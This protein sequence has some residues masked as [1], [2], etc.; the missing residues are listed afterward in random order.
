[1]NCGNGHHIE[2]PQAPFSLLLVHIEPL[3]LVHADV[4]VLTLKAILPT[5]NY[6]LIH[7]SLLI[8]HKLTKLI[9]K[10]CEFIAFIVNFDLQHIVDAFTA[11]GVK[12][13]WWGPQACFFVYWQ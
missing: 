5:S 13:L 4:A 8:L 10:Q 12:G 1:M 6:S 3:T 9:N 7:L 2:L 11:I